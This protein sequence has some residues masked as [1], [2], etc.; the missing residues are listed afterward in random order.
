M[1][2]SLSV[3]D[4]YVA[5]C[6]YSLAGRVLQKEREREKSVPD[7]K[8]RERSALSLCLSVRVSS[9]AYTR[10]SQNVSNYDEK[11]CVWPAPS[12]I[13]SS[14]VSKRDFFSSEHTSS[15][16]SL[17]VFRVFLPFFLLLLLLQIRLGV[18]CV[19]KVDF[20]RFSH[21]RGEQK[22]AKREQKK[23]KKRQSREKSKKKSIKRA[24]KESK[25]KSK[26]KSKKRD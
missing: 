5:I 19:C 6:C 23:Q 14:C 21:V 11:L 2:L 1:Y 7:L 9:L 22:R 25:K 18:V 12:D 10:E 13:S 24:K 15:R 3:Y 20:F 26:K 4:V 16:F 8:F 17:S